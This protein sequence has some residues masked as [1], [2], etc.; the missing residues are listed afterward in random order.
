MEGIKIYH[1]MRMTGRMCDELVNEAHMLVRASQE[2]GF[3]ALNP[4]IEEKVKFAHVPLNASPERL[5]EY[6]KRDKAMIREADIVLDYAT[7]NQ[8]DGAN[9]EI[10]YSRWCLW[11]PTVRVWSN[12]GGMIS[13]LE[14]DLVVPT[15]GEAMQLIVEQWGTYPKLS[16]WRKEMWERCHK[17]WLEEQEKMNRR[18][19]ANVQLEVI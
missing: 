19:Q 5:E 10:G 11:K 1:S 15:L 9:K 8:S 2:Y 7:H 13:K 12:P 18:Y 17:P 16:A 4:V 3:I 14:D 6:W